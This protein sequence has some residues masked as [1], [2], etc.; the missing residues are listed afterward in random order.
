MMH[1]PLNVLD[2]L[3]LKKIT[4][5]LLKINDTN[6]HR[7]ALKSLHNLLDKLWPF[8]CRGKVLGDQH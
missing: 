4:K 6:Q 2:T 8:M 7:P 5:A 3:Y 1:D